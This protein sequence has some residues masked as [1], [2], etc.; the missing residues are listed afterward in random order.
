VDTIPYTRKVVE[1]PELSGRKVVIKQHGISGYKIKRF[2]I[3]RTADGAK[4]EEK[5]T[6]TYPPTTEIYEV[7]I[8]FDVSLLPSLPGA[9]DED[10]PSAPASA[11]PAAG[12]TTPAPAAGATASPPSGAPGASTAL[13]SAPALSTAAAPAAP[14]EPPAFTLV[15]APGAH[16]P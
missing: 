2:R 3:L 14:P 12:T 9:E 10:T 6:D 4:R 16:A 8:G 11:T 5:N 15:E 13:P 1:D 7:P